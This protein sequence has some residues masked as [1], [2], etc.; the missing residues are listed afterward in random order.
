MVSFKDL[1]TVAQDN[2]NLTAGVLVADQL[3]PD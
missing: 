1:V 2:F 3:Q